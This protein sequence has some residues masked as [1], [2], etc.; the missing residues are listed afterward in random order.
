LN[1]V[2]FQIW[3]S[4]GSRCLLNHHPVLATLLVRV[5]LAPH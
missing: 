3:A 4:P 1:L 2:A 5:M